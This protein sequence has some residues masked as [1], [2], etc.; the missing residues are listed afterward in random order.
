MN[1][2]LASL[3]ASRQAGILRYLERLRRRAGL[4]IVYVNRSIDEV[5]RLAI[6]TVSAVQGRVAAVGPASTSG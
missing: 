4:P 2:P 1:E 5:A 3:D 6:T